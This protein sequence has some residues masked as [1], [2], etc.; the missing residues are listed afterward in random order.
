MGSRRNATSRRSQLRRGARLR[1]LS[2]V[3][4]SLLGVV[5]AVRAKSDGFG[6]FVDRFMGGRAKLA[7]R[8]SVPIPPLDE[9]MVR[10]CFS[11]VGSHVGDLAVLTNFSLAGINYLYGGSRAPNIPRKASAVQRGAQLRFVSKWWGLIRN[12]SRST[13]FL[14]GVAA[15]LTFAGIASATSG[16]N[17]IASQ[18]DGLGKCGLVDPAS[19]L[20]TDVQQLF[21]EPSR[22]FPD[23]LDGIP[24]VARYSCGARTEYASLVVAQ[25]RSRKV[26]LTRRPMCSASIFVVPK[27]GTDRLREVWDGSLISAASVAP[28]APRW[29]ADPAALVSLEASCVAPIYLSSRDG[30]CFYDQLRLDDALVPYFGR[31]QVQIA[32]LYAVGFGIDEVTSCLLDELEAKLFCHG[33]VVSSMP[34]VAH[35]LRTFGICGT[36]ANDGILSRSWFPASPVLD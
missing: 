9:N 34:N 11:C 5:H 1:R 28:E 18:V 36:T 35:G 27:R 14:E 6:L 10:E 33:L 24:Q 7:L 30:A 20:P 21:R 2:Q 12:A 23:G 8:H 4:S 13:D 22:L 26:A 25:L 19:C 31:P 16:A 17:L 29:L 32:E 15:P 3:I